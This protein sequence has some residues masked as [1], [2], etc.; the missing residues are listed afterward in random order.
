MNGGYGKYMF[1]QTA[2]IG[3]FG[4]GYHIKGKGLL[5]NMGNELK[6]YGI[7][8]GDSDVPVVVKDFADFITNELA[9]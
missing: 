5:F 3:F 6:S 1:G 2:R 9:A 8:A 7:Y 4:G